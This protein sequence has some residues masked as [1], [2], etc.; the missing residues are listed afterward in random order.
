MTEL[1]TAEQIAR[2][3]QVRP[4]TVKAWAKSGRIPEHRLSAKVR[5]YDLSEVLEAVQRR[6][7]PRHA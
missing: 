6:E 2:R 7:E 3:L 5:R 1:L 4:S